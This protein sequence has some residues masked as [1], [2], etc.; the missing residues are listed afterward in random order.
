MRSSTFRSLTSSHARR[1]EARV[2]RAHEDRSVAGRLRVDPPGT[3]RFGHVTQLEGEGIWRT[4]LA[5][6]HFALAIIAAA[7][8]LSTSAPSPSP[9]SLF[10]RRTGVL[11]SR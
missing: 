4:Q 6:A 1:H 9:E 8:L 2:E 3:L 7:R 5:E 11:Y 10:P